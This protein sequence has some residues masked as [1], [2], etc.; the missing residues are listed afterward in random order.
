ML[1]KRMRIAAV[2]MAAAVMCATAASAATTEE[3]LENYMNNSVSV[4]DMAADVQMK[5]IGSIQTD[6]KVEGLSKISAGAAMNMQMGFQKEPLMIGMDAT[7]A[8]GALGMSASMD[9]DFYLVE[10]EEGALG[11]YLKAT[12]GNGVQDTGWQHESLSQEELAEIVQ[13]A[14]EELTS[15]LG[16]D[17][18][19]GFDPSALEDMF[20]SF[21]AEDLGQAVSFELTDENAMINDIACYELTQRQNLA[22]LVPIIQTALEAEG[23]D[24]TTGQLISL[25][26]GGMTSRTSL[27]IA[28]DTYRAQAIHEDLNESDFSSLNMMLNYY[29]I[30][31][32]I[33]EAMD[34]DVQSMLNIGTY[35][36]SLDDFSMD[37]V[38]DYEVQQ[39]VV[40]PQEAQTATGS[41]YK[42]PQTSYYHFIWEMLEQLEQEVTREG[43]DIVIDQVDEIETEP[44]EFPLDGD[45]HYDIDGNLIIE[46]ETE[47]AET[48]AAETEAA[49]TEAAETEAAETEAQT[50]PEVV[51]L[52]LPGMTDEAETEAE[53]EIAVETEAEADTEATVETEY[54]DVNERRM[55]F[56]G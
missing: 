22:D 24:A 16:I 43:G 17:L 29:V 5:L 31:S 44:E 34:S 20:G 14:I 13:E 45:V 12:L 40:V 27:Y 9:F 15:E 8:A 4:N 6:S 51:E 47:A 33:A 2:A 10:E 35:N 28:K 11:I 48:E 26:L 36:F 1:K 55:K 46:P 3:V 19:E 39:P 49:E 38:Y 30:R 21:S 23:I 42:A 37:I 18:D 52:V 25:V 54:Y 50:E 7:M 53:T 32:L 56:R 41:I